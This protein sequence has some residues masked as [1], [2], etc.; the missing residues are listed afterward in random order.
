MTDLPTNYFEDY[1]KRRTA[2]YRPYW[3]ALGEFVHAFSQV[4]RELQELVF[5][6]SG[7]SAQDGKAL[8]HGMRVDAAKDAINRLLDARGDTEI[9]ARLEEPFAHLGHIAGMRN[10]L[11]HWGAAEGE[12][13][14]FLV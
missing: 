1:L 5:H 4:E 11:I 8:F 7:V 9:K 2:R 3:A 6:L 12:G 10:N 14:W 13:E